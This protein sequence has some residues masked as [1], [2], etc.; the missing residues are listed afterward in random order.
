MLWQFY[1]YHQ[2]SFNL[3]D[4]DSRGRYDIDE[5]HPSDVMS[6]NEEC[7]AYIIL[8]ESGVADFVAMEQA[9]IIGVEIPKLSDIF[10][11]PKYR[12]Q[13]VAS[14]VVRALCLR[15]PVGDMWRSL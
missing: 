4:I 9:E 12:S 3:E 8:I 1:Q 11:L 6:G 5:E 10:I 15:K 14:K 7:D 13:G 2:S